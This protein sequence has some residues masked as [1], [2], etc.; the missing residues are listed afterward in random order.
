M[1]PTELSRTA[2]AVPGDWRRA[3]VRGVGMALLIGV[4]TV[5]CILLTRIPGHV[6]SVWLP[7]AL[8]LGLIRRAGPGQRGGVGLAT[9]AGIL[10]G[11]L[12]CDFSFL[13]PVGLT[14]A[15]LVEIALAVM[16]TD[17][18]LS[19]PEPVTRPSQMVAVL[20]AAGVIAPAVGGLLGARPWR[21]SGS[22]LSCRCS[23]SGGSARSW[24]RC[25][26]C[27]RC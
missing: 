19:G 7:N 13:A 18:I 9:L 26:C 25:C 1:T 23:N 5:G 14:L 16:L 20:V 24:G 4:V 10:V 12:V 27:R 17:R 11:N 2:M 21:C 6:A 15:N 8:A 3:C 22:L